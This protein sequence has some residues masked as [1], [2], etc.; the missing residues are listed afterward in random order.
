[1]NLD[2]LGVVIGRIRAH[3][4]RFNM[5][6]LGEPNEILTDEGCGSFACIAEEITGDQAV[7]VLTKIS[8]GVIDL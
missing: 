6:F 4:E 8:Q 1:M 3:A 2:A 5:R 7:T